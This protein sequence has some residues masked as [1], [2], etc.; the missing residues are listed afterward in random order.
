VRREKQEKIN[1]EKE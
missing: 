1:R